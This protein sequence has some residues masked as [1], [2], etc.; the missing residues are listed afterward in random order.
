M[1]T[2]T[3]TT[4][5]FT[6]RPPVPGD[7]PAF[8]AFMMSDR[9]TAFGSHRDLARAFRSFAAE[10]GHWQIFGHGMWAVTARGDD[11][12]LAL[13]GPWTPP[14]WPEPEVGWMVL[15]AAAEGTGLATEAAQAA[16]ADAYD[17]LGW[18]T[19]VSYIGPENTRSIRLAEKL[20]ARLDPAAPQPK[21]D[22][23]VLVY[24]HP[25]P[26]VRA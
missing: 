2:V 3:L 26:A 25:R 17:R 10:L 14:D 18:D 13:I 24:R 12:C 5:R 7:W 8:H 11:T 9:S 15:D 23:P 21:P 6:L 4:D 1:T 20:G 22:D 19:V 16:I